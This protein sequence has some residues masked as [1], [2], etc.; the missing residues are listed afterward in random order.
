MS[1]FVDYAAVMKAFEKEARVVF[2]QRV[3]SR[4]WRDFARWS[5]AELERGV[6]SLYSG[7]IS[8]Y[9]YEQGSTEC[10]RHMIYILCQGKLAGDETDG[11]RIETAEFKFVRQLEKL[12]VRCQ[13]ID[14][15]AGL[16]LLRCTTSMQVEAPY[17]WVA[18]EWENFVE[19]LEDE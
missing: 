17:Y 4:T 2:S 11:E 12:A 1:D 6:A 19:G 10:G 5:A 18:S 14:L 8:E 7:G 3:F 13:P 16:K 9:P 15:L